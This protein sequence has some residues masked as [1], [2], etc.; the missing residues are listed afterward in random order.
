M[1]RLL[2][3]APSG[4]YHLH[5]GPGIWAELGELARSFDGVVVVS[6]QNVAALYAHRLPFPLCVLEP[7]EGTKSFDQV[8]RLVDQ[9]AELELSRYSL[10]VALGGGVIGD[11]VGFTASLFR[12]GISYVQ[13]PTTLVAQVDSSVGGKTGINTPRGKNLVGAFYQPKGVFIDPAVLKTLPRREITNG[14]GE[15]LK[16]GVIQ[17][18]ALFELVSRSIPAFYQVALDVVGPVIRR[19]VEIKGA[20]VAAD[21]TDWG[22]RRILNH[23]HTFG[24]ALEQATGYR[25][26]RHG[27]AVLLGMFLEARLA[28]Y[29]G[30]LPAA[31]LREIEAALLRVQLEYRFDQVDKQ[32][33]LRAL[34]QDKKNR[35]GAISFILPREIGKVEEVLLSAAEVEKF[36]DEVMGA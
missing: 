11:L 25:V 31:S 36:W 27:E 6:D 3:Q 23:G 12:R 32:T 30:L 13:V 24:H 29:L 10:V 26:Y 9:W 20:I 1:D 19:C 34:G 2:I 7:G 18:G 16:Y 4:S 17:D 22:L 15:V 14:L 33:L 8:A 21:E 5:F 35:A 28:H